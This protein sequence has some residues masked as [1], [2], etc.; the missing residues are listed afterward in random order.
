MSTPG[1]FISVKDLMLLHSSDQYESMRRHHKAV[2]DALTSKTNK[3]AGK[4]K[5]YLTVA[6]YCRYADLN[7]EEVCAFLKRNSTDDPT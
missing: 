1:I 6:E 4:I 5:P 7:Y 3:S 2:R